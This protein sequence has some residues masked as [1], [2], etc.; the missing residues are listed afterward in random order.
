MSNFY[1]FFA[2][3]LSK[4]HF[5]GWKITYVDENF[6]FFP[7]NSNFVTH[8]RAWCSSP[9]KP[10]FF[11][12]TFLIFSKNPKNGPKIRKKM[13]FLP[14]NGVGVRTP[15]GGVQAWRAAVS[16]PRRHRCWLIRTDPDFRRCE[17]MGSKM[18][19]FTKNSSFLKNAFSLNNLQKLEFF[20]DYLLLRTK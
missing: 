2:I 19:N 3:F 6:H 10:H 9:N 7:K 14:K 11:F 18:Q 16:A 8:S 13:G 17:K 12:G 20:L 15:K 5:F 1:G 4:K